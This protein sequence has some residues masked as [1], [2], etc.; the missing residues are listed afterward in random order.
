MQIGVIG[1]DDFVTGFRLSGVSHVFSAEKNLDNAI[2]QALQ[3]KEIGVLVLEEEAYNTL[4]NQKTRKRL[5]RLVKPVIVTIS[6]KGKE[7]NLR[8]M[9]KRSLGVDLWKS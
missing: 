7:T 2:E 3:I 8:E 5:E 4:V 9:I 1:N 6:D